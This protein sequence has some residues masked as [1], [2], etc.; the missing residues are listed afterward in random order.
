MKPPKNYYVDKGVLRKRPDICPAC[1][2]EFEWGTFD[3]CGGSLLTEL[4]TLKADYERLNKGFNATC[5]LL[6][7]SIILGALL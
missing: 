4:N 3:K 6:G 5:V 2:S 1:G 7:I